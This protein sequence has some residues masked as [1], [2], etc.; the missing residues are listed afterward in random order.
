MEFW[1]ET[2]GDEYAAVAERGRIERWIDVYPTKAS[3]GRL[4][5][6]DLQLVPYLFLNWGGTLEDVFT[7]VHEMGHSIHSYLANKNQPYHDADSSLFVAEVASVASESLFFEWMLAR[8]TDPTE[9]W[10]CS[11]NG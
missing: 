7:L 6:G 11:I 3:G 9:A 5:V 4:F 8:T 2:F 10:R 1:K